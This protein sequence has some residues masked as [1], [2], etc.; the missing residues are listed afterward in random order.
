MIIKTKIFGEI[1]VDETKLITF[2]NGIV[3]FPELKDFLLSNG[4]R[5]IHNEK[6]II[7]RIP[8]YIRIIYRTS[9]F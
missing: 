9:I 3:G 5:S 4:S 8:R 2:V 6:F 1:T 7:T